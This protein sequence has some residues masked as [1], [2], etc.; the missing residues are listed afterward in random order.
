MGVR[1]E[2]ISFIHARL[3]RF[4]GWGEEA[5]SDDWKRQP[6]QGSWGWSLL[7]DWKRL[8]GAAGT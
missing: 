3:G 7:L 5:E 8:E 4:L 2:R 1:A 6:H